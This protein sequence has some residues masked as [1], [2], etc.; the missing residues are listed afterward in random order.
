MFNGTPTKKLS[1][2]NS[3]INQSK[4]V[5][6]R[7]YRA[8]TCTITTPLLPS[9]IGLHIFKQITVLLVYTFFKTIIIFEIYCGSLLLKVQT[10]PYVSYI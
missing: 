2:Y 1:G 6:T 10:T 8:Y 4:E 3:A 9:I 7:A 5:I